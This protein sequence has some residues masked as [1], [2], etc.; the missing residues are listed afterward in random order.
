MLDRFR[1]GV[2]NLA[3]FMTA[4]L[5]RIFES[6]D[7]SA[8]INRAATLLNEGKLIVVPTETVYGIAGRLDHAEARERLTA[9]RSGEENKP[10]TIH[11]ARPQDAT[12]YLGSV[13][14]LG[15]R[16]MRKLW[17][18]PVALRFNVPAERRAAVTEQLGLEESAVYS[19]GSIMLRCPD[20]PVTREILSRVEGPV[21]MTVAAFSGSASRPEEF[22]DALSDQ[23]DLILDAGPTQFSKPSTIV[24]VDGDDYEILREGVYDRRIL[25]RQ[26]R[27]TIL[28][29]CSGNTCRSP[30]AEALTRKL[31]AERLNVKPAELE[32]K[33]FTVLSAGAMAM[34]GARAAPQAIETVA[35]MGADLSSHRSRPLSV[36]LIH[37]ADLIL[38]MSAAHTRAILAMV[39]SAADKVVPLNPEGDVEDP[40]GLDI[41]VYRSL[42]GKM[43]QMIEQR[44]TEREL[45]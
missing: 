16:M 2:D 34:P 12:Q 5:I 24:R 4:S 30:M 23:V 3:S 35:E 6:A 26:L 20:H 45:I 19:E 31:L 43:E 18:G 33:G 38:P 10:L 13:S 39:P 9:M 11:L 37:Q 29:V 40:I 28:Y 36:E 1:E 7:Y 21:V 41:D 25:E 44:L 42:A 32:S 27:T 15:Q 8:D 22:A 17:P 14:E